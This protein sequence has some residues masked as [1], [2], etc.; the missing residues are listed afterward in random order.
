MSTA[1]FLLAGLASDLAARSSGCARTRSPRRRPPTT[2]SSWHWG[3]STASGRAP[4]WL[5][6]AMSAVLVATM[7]AVDHPRLGGRSAGGE[8]G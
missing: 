1:M 4:G 6:P 2:S 5:A 7:C 8:P 3:S